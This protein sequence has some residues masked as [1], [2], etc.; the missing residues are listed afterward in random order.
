MICQC[1]ADANNYYLPK[2]SALQIIDLLIT[3]KS[4]YFAQPRSIIVSYHCKPTDQPVDVILVLTENIQ[5]TE[6]QPGH[7]N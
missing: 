5:A 1:I 4:R 3:D 6:D 2:P 7:K